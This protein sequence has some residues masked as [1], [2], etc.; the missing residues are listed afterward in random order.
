[1]EDKCREVINKISEFLYGED[2]LVTSA[3]ENRNL[4]TYN[5]DMDEII[6]ILEQIKKVENE[7]TEEHIK[8]LEIYKRDF[9]L[10]ENGKNGIEKMYEEIENIYENIEEY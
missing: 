4:D 6:E 7:F 9:L 8:K 1:M 10:I 5:W 3:Y 2:G